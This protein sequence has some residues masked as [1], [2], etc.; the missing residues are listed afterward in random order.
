[1]VVKKVSLSD[2]KELIQDDSTLLVVDAYADWCGPC[3]FSSPQFEKL[4]Q[5]YES[6]ATFIKFNVDEESQLGQAFNIRSIPAFF[7]LKGNN[8][9]KDD[10]HPAQHI[11]HA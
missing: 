2:F 3:K 7:I 6:K 10:G 4:S 1:M 8:N 11:K 9:E 5:A